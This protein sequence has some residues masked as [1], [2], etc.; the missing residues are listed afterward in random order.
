MLGGNA[1]ELT[2]PNSCGLFSTSVRKD[3]GIGK[4]VWG[5]IFS[6]GE[7]RRTGREAERFPRRGGE[8][9]LRIPLP[10]EGDLEKTGKGDL[11]PGGFRARSREPV[12][13]DRGKGP[14]PGREERGSPGGPESG[15][16]RRTVVEGHRWV[17]RQESPPTRP[18]SEGG[19]GGEDL[20][21]P[22]PR[23][24]EKEKGVS[25]LG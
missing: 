9:L 17:R 25:P 23:I 4:H 21:T 11:V 19:R 1:H 8:A 5:G 16:K 14:L 7:G 22:A 20:V 10:G 18:D 2:P 6:F 3:G 15:G 24:Y 12:E 13:P